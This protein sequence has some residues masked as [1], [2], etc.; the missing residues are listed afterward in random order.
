MGFSRLNIMSDVQFICDTKSDLALLPYSSMGSTCYVIDESATYM[1]NSKQEWIKQNPDG[2]GGNSEQINLDNYY[3]KDEIDQ[4]LELESSDTET[5]INTKIE[6]L[7][8]RLDIDDG[9]FEG[10]EI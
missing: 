5:L 9:I 4:R 7:E 6:E 8:S 3:T 1:C 2:N 10:G